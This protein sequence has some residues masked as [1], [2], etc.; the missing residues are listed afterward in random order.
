MGPRSDN[1]S[2]VVIG[3]QGTDIDILS[4][5]RVRVI[6]RDAALTI[7]GKNS[8]EWTRSDQWYLIRRE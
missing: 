6:T 8:D 2:G 4:A 3:L 7:V 1:G 5:R